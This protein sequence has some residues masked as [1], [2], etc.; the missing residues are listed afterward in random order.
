MKNLVSKIFGLSLALGISL[1]GVNAFAAGGPINKPK[2][3]EWTFAGPFGYWDYGQLQRG[4][5]IYQ[6]ACSACHSIDLV[7][8]RNLQEIGFSED[9]VKA[10][11]AEY[12][13]TD[14]PNADGEM[15]D[16]PAVPA[17]LIPGPWANPE[18][19][20]AA[21]GAVP[22]DFSLLAKARAPERGFP[23][24]VFDI[25]TMY[26]EN[27]PDYIYSLLT[28]YKDVSE[29]PAH[30]EL[31]EDANYNPYFIAGPT[32]AMAQPLDDD[33]V[34]Y[35]DG[36]P[37]TLDQHAKDIAAFMMWAAEP[38]LIERKAM[39]FKVI[40]FLLVLALLMYLTKKQV[41]RELKS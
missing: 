25:F 21:Q 11:A 3:V 15:F 30:Y 28:G 8:F 13:V 27:G 38:K 41:F 19:A 12:E 31:D 34:E 22:P 36:T 40:A 35:D 26:A 2:E 24:F 16:R 14:G 39:G 9:E 4:F 23:T 17:D 29:A 18:E 10:I 1:V 32:L 33:S 7:A 20:A 37:A 6:E 5:K